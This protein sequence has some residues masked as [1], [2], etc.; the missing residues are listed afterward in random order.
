MITTPLITKVKS[1]GGTLYTFTSTSKDLTRVATNNANYKFKFSHFACLNLPHIMRGNMTLMNYM[2]HVDKRVFRTLE[3]HVNGEYFN[4]DFSLTPEYENKLTRSRLIFEKPSDKVPLEFTNYS[5]E[6]NNVVVHKIGV[7]NIINQNK[8]ELHFKIELQ[9]DDETTRVFP[10]NGTPVYNYFIYD[11]D[12]VGNNVEKGMYLEIFDNYEM[13]NDFNISIAEHFQNY[14]LNQE[15]AILNDKGLFKQSNLR[16]PAERIFFN[17]LEKIGAIRFKNSG[18]RDVDNNILF[19]EIDKNILDRTVQYLGNIDAI[20]TVDVNGDTFGEVYLYIPSGVGATP[21]IYFQKKNDESYQVGARITL[22]TEKIVGRENFREEDTPVD[23]ISLKAIYDGDI[24]G[25]YYTLDG[26]YCIDFRDSSYGSSSDTIMSINSE[27]YEN[28][29]FN[30]VLIYYDLIKNTTN[31]KGEDVQ[32]YATNLYGVLF[33]DNFKA[34]NISKTDNYIAYIEGYPTFR[35]SELDDGNSFALKVDLKFDTAPS[36]TMVRNTIDSY[37]DPNSAKGFGIYM[38]ALEELHKCIDIFYTQQ[39]TI[40]TLQDRIEQLESIVY[41]IP[42]YNMIQTEINVINNQLRQTGINTSNNVQMLKMIVDNTTKLN[43][44]INGEYPTTLAIDSSKL[45]P[46]NGI[47]ITSSKK[48]DKINIKNTLQKYKYVGKISLDTENT[49]GYMYPINNV[50]NFNLMENS[51]LVLLSVNE[52]FESDMG[53]DEPVVFNINTS[54]CT[55]KTGQSVEFVI[56]DDFKFDKI[57]HVGLVIQT[58]SKSGKPVIIKSF[59]KDEL[60]NMGNKNEIEVVC[61]NGDVK[62][63][64]DFITIIR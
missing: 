3:S 27:S 8:T 29:E 61:L 33:L 6:N 36:S 20:N 32:E 49:E 47:E 15:S 55:W 5:L 38:N 19:D 16:S 42:D 9:F 10:E 53:L 24:G 48:G 44:L 2:E 18:D 34:S 56:S 46:V 11:F 39:H 57:R 40:Y 63:G 58:L 50:V 52:S 41:N 22:G 45:N 43:Q 60:M 13:N 7:E 35:S 31:N 30:C 26:G 23:G 1:D 28:F 4:I 12:K 64:N 25:N 17:W 14:I 21:Q 59:T 51:N 37:D 62:T 54:K